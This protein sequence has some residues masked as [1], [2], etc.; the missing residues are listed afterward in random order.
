M[1]T[2][3]DPNPV[4]L[5]FTCLGTETAELKQEHTPEASKQT[6]QSVAGSLSLGRGITAIILAAQSWGPALW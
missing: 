3:L 5:E 2:S 1:K 6:A 4:P